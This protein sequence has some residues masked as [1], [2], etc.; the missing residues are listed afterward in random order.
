MAADH[1]PRHVCAAVPGPPRCA[2]TTMTTDK[3]FIEVIAIGTERDV[4]RACSRQRGQQTTGAGHGAG[5]EKGDSA[6]G[7]C[8]RHLV[9]N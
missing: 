9:L 2:P 8:G 6:L 4:A 1:K 3:A 5:A 7:R